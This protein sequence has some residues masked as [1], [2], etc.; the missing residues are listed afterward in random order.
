MYAHAV[1]I[2]DV[3]LALIMMETNN[4]IFQ[5]SLELCQ[6]KLSVCMTNHLFLLFHIQVLYSLSRS[7]IQNTGRSSS[8]LTK[9][10][11]VW[12]HKKIDDFKA[13]LTCL[14]D[15]IACKCC[16]FQACSWQK[17]RKVSQK[18]QAFLPDQRGDR[19]G[20]IGGVDTPETVKLISTADRCKKIQCRHC[21]V[22]LSESKPS[23]STS[24]DFSPFS[25]GSENSESEFHDSHDPCSAA[26]K[27][28][29]MRVNLRD[30]ALTSQRYGLKDRGSAM[31]VTS[32]LKGVGLV[33]RDAPGLVTDRSKIRREKSKVREEMKIRK[34]PRSFPL[35]VLYFDGLEDNMITQIKQGTTFYRRTVKEEHITI[36]T[37]PRSNY[38][39]HVVPQSENAQDICDSIHQLVL[40]EMDFQE[41][42]VI[43]CD[44]TVVNT[45][46]KGS[47]IKCFENK[48][49]RSLQWIL[50]LLYLNELLFRSLFEFFDRDTSQLKSFTAPIG[51]HQDHTSLFDISEAIKSGRCPPDLSNHARWLNCA[52][53]ILRLYIS[54]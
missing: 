36:I 48:L 6:N 25:H 43:G 18:E 2:R 5:I 34:Q 9:P 40:K 17:N 13:T 4:Q 53:R 8:T 24:H 21:K 37:A 49:G 35:K 32:L 19:V 47:L 51:L 38:L 27:P 1:L 42:T 41:L 10:I 52:N 22:P 26:R 46:A 31:I 30:T 15:I 29:Q 54:T 39:G 12:L 33:S 11:K 20:R 45:G 50:C 23:Y 14:F 16:N 7:S 28:S 44:R 3:S